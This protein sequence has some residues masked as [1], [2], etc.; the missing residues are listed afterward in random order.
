MENPEVKNETVSDEA[1]QGSEQSKSTDSAGSTDLTGTT[2]ST[3]NELTQSVENKSKEIESLE[4]VQVSEVKIADEEPK[5]NPD[6]E[7]IKSIHELIISDEKIKELILKSKIN[8]SDNELKI[9]LD[10]LGYLNAQSTDSNQMK[11]II[12]EITK[13]LSDG[14]LELHEIPE[15]ISVVTANIKEVNI[16]L[17]TKQISILLKLIIYVLI[18]VKVVSINSE[19]FELISKVIDTS[20]KLLELYVNIPTVKTKCKCWPF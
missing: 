11:Q 15:L 2:N 3:T 20:L 4:M 13:V 14:K 9:I 10:V 6:L 5:T 19:D 17:S 16:K 18:E 1:T 7:L 12:G 8:I